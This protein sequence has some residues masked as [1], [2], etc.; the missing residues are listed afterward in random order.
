MGGG[1]AGPND[2]LHKPEETIGYEELL[3]AGGRAVPGP[4]VPWEALTPTVQNL[5]C[6]QS[7]PMVLTGGSGSAPAAA[8]RDALYLLYTPPACRTVAALLKRA[9]S[10]SPL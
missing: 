3:R 7:L 6:G 2:R 8:C 9:A 4:K 1:G 5:S 10:P